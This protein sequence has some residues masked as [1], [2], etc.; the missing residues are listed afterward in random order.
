[1]VLILDGGSTYVL[2]SIPQDAHAALFSSPLWTSQA[3]YDFPDAV[4]TLH[5][6]YLE[7]GAE[8]ISC[9]TYQQSPDTM[10]HL[11]GPGSDADVWNAGMLA[12]SQACQKH[13]SGSSVLTLG[14]YAAMLGNGAEYFHVFNDGDMESLREF[15]RVRLQHFIQSPAWSDVQYIA[16]ETLPDVKEAFLILDVLQALQHSLA[17]KRVWISFSCSGEGATDRLVEG[18]T[19]LLRDDRTQ[20]LLWGIGLNC[21][22]EDVADGV[23]CGVENL[24]RGT[25]LY[26]VLYPDN[27]EVWDPVKRIFTGT[28]KTP[29]TW[30]EPFKQWSSLNHGRLVFGGW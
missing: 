12:S 5:R 19:S 17:E 7:A 20:K 28:P 15:H 29:D 23:V 13:G 3:L 4:Q 10:K 1:M 2:Q 6:S 24:I 8:L 21:F 11:T 22:K 30:A 9:M 26:L 14:T 25:S 16:F 27:G 18:I